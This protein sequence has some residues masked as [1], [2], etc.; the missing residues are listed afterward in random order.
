MTASTSSKA[1]AQNV[2]KPKYSY[3]QR[4]LKAVSDLRQRHKKDTVHVT[5]IKNQVK[6]NAESKNDKLGPHWQNRV[7]STVHNLEDAGVLSQT[8]RKASVAF[9]PEVKRHLARE[10]RLSTPLGLSDDNEY[11]LF[12]NLHHKFSG[13][14]LQSTR[15]R[16]R[17]LGASSLYDGSTRSSRSMS[18]MTKAELIAEL[19]K[20]RTNMATPSRS[21]GSPLKNPPSTVNEKNG[22]PDD[23]EFAEGNSTQV[24][25]EPLTP[26]INRISQ[27]RTPSG[28]M[29]TP[30][31]A[32]ISRISKQPTPEPSEVDQQSDVDQQTSFDLGDMDFGGGMDEPFVPQDDSMNAD[33]EQ[34]ADNVEELKQKLD[35]ATRDRDALATDYENEIKELREKLASKDNELLVAGDRLA[36]KTEE[37]DK[38]TSSMVTLQVSYNDLVTR[39]TSTENE[40]DTTKKDSEAQ[41]ALRALELEGTKSKLAETEA[42][43]AAAEQKIIELNKQASADVAALNTEN[44][45]LKAR[46][47]ALEEQ[48]EAAE[49]QAETLNASVNDLQ[50]QLEER[51]GQLATALEVS[52]NRQAMVEELRDANNR[53]QSEIMDLKENVTGSR[54]LVDQVTAQL[55]DRIGQHNQALQEV[56][57]LRVQII[58]MNE[59]RQ[60]LQATLNQTTEQLG[61][62]ETINQ[63]LQEALAVATQEATEAGTQLVARNEE[64]E[65]A[66]K[67]YASLA[68]RLA[69]VTDNLRTTETEVEELRTKLGEMEERAEDAEADADSLRA[70]LED[71]DDAME[72]V[73]ETF[74]RI[75]EFEAAIKRAKRRVSEVAPASPSQKRQRRSEPKA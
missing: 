31:G 45:T 10:R 71:R 22:H 58:E 57:Q 23:D 19:T 40:L 70:Q 24:T 69:E 36:E 32:Y 56:Q 65:T 43:L 28:L 61:V 5:A 20:Y 16:R 75:D 25:N 1:K 3:A 4:V 66:T 11:S 39:L 15:N 72:E 74:S 50:T 8:P 52:E 46:V 26:L 13:G 29:R 62:S 53:A 14:D 18:N 37:C 33:E 41:L 59:T 54:R 73:K 64:L 44:T 63:E 42:S 6:K 49:A 38:A 68:E 48:L 27:L 12:K 9:T 35:A 7:T 34:E 51:D 2:Q 30:S 21:G 47:T 55:G 17:S 67:E 60:E